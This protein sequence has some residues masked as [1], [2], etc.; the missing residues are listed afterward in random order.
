MSD[1]IIGKAM[2]YVD[3]SIA[4]TVVNNSVTHIENRVFLVS[5]L[6]VGNAWH[7]KYDDS[8]YCVI[9][10]L[11]DSVETPLGTFDS[12]MVTVT[13]AGYAEMTKWYVQGYG[14]IRSVYR[15]PGPSSRGLIVVLT[16][17]ISL[18][19]RDRENFHNDRKEI[20]IDK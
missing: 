20:L 15:A 17:M 6:K 10:S 18:S 9:V 1:S 12:A 19:K 11:S 3:D 14:L 2:Y 16:E 8:I 7:E 5:P 4:M 13:R